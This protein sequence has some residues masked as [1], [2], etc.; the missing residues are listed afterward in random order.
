MIIREAILGEESKRDAILKSL[1]QQ[2]ILL[3]EHNG[4]CHGVLLTEGNDDKVY[5]I[6]I[7]DYRNN[8][9]FHYHDLHE[10]LIIENHPVYKKP[11]I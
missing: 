8:R 10:L 6:K 7:V 4:W 2:V 3:D 1:G 9:S 11:E 5:Q